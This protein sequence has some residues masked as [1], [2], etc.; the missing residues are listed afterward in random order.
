MHVGL[1]EHPGGF[2]RMATFYAER[3]R[4]GMGLM[5]TGGISPNDAGRPM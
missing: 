4:G 3:A 1:E 5:V 2:E